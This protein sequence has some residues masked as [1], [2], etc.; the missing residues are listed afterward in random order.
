MVPGGQAQVHA[1]CL[2]AGL[3]WGLDLYDVD[4]SQF[5]LSLTSHVGLKRLS[6]PPCPSVRDFQH[7]VFKGHLRRTG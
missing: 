4:H 6:C 3:A 5:H 1:S 7:Q 2:A